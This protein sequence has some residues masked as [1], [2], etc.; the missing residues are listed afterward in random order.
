MILATTL[1]QQAHE[2]SAIESGVF[3]HELLSGLLGAADVN[4]DQ[5]IEYTELQAFI[6]AANRCGPTICSKPATA[7]PTVI[8]SQ[9]NS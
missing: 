1:G 5:R 8:C 2:W 7:R 6:A 4:A 3:T 9:Q